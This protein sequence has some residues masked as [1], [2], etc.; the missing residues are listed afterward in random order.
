MK[1]IEAAQYAKQHQECTQDD[2]EAM[3]PQYKHQLPRSAWI[4]A[5]L[6]NIDPSD[7]R[8]INLR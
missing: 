2:I 7:H 8:F 3:I 6:K 5:F 1:A 4:Q